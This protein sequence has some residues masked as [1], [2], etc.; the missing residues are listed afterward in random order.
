MPTAGF[1]WQGRFKLQ[2]IQKGGHFLACARYIERNPVRANIVKEAQEYLYSSARFYCLGE[3][4]G[5]TVESLAFAEFGQD[6]DLRRVAYKEFLRNFDREEE[7]AFRSLEIPQGDRGFL[8]R[9]IKRRGRFLPKR[10]GRPR[11]RIVA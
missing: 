6:V 4:D 9:L 10:G 7:E 5:L 3:E 2:P 8:C 1:L 11:E